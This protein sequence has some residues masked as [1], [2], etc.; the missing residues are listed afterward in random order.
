MT[1]NDLRKAKE[2]LYESIV[3]Y[4]LSIERSLKEFSETSVHDNDKL[5]FISETLVQTNNDML[6]YFKE[7]DKINREIKA[8]EREENKQTKS[9]YS[10]TQDEGYTREGREL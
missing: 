5:I 3:M 7:I 4:K 1:T 9:E 8:N 10:V 2:K 6:K